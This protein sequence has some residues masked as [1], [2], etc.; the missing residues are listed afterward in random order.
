MNLKE[1]K[2]GS[3]AVITLI[4]L[5]AAAIGYLVF[6]SLQGSMHELWALF[7]A[8]VVATVIVWAFGLVFKNVSVY[9]PYWSVFPPVVFTA[10]M[11]YKATFTLPVI[12]LLI[13]IWYWAIRLTGNWA[14]T[15]KGL[16]HEDWRYTR[17]REIQSPFLFQLTNFFGLNMVPTVVVFGAMLSGFGIFESGNSANFFTWLGFAM[18]LS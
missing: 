12:L 7:L 16:G 13:A 9:D 17:Y 15:F 5:I 10:W 8:D 2:F 3:I 18:C 11:F 1:N 4:Y 6:N 14:F